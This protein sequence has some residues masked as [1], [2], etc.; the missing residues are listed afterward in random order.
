[1]STRKDD[2]CYYY[3]EKSVSTWQE[4]PDHVY[5]TDQAK[6]M[7]RELKTQDAN[8]AL[9]SIYRVLD[10]VEKFNQLNEAE[11]VLMLKFLTDEEED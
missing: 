8:S 7:M 6:H 3:V 1:M 4:L 11:Q 2:V 9:T 10:L 5:W